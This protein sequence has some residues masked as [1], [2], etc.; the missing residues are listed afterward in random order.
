MTSVKSINLY[1]RPDKIQRERY[2]KLAERTQSS[3][4]SNVSLK[5]PTKQSLPQQLELFEQVEEPPLDD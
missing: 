1:I 4:N 5:E 2:D 3:T